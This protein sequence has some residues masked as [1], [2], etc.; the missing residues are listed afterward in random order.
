MKHAKSLLTPR[1]RWLAAIGMQPADRLP[2][3]PKINAAYLRFQAPPFRDM[4]PEEAHR[5]LGSDRQQGIRDGICEHR[6]LTAVETRPDGGDTSVTV[7]RSPHGECRLVRRFDEASGAWHPVAFPVRTVDDIRV[8][9]AVY[10]D[11]RPEPDADGLEEARAQAAAA[12]PEAVTAVTVGISPLMHWVEWLAGVENAHYLLADHPA[13]VEELFAVMHAFLLRKTE[14]VC[15][16]NP[17]DL[18]YFSENTSTTLI[19]P[20]QYRRYCAGHLREYGALTRAAGREMVLHMC[21]RLKALLPDL[22]GVPARA[23]EAFTAPPLG[24]T[25]LLDGRRACPDKC[26]VGGTHAMLWTR[27]ADEIAAAIEADLAALP[28][29]CGIVVSSAGVMPPVCRPETI[30]QVAQRVAA[31]VFRE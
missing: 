9:T 31:V 14:I 21:G 29:L 2:F 13:E 22:A 16:R 11:A 24:D 27:P 12:G 5:W 19:S 26:L 30:R 23:F 15:A 4:S 8:L 20:A 3:W 6:R 28:H 25:T 10:A 1:E 7:Y 18:V 17:A